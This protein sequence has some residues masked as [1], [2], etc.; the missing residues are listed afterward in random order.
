MGYD[1]LY[2]CCAGATWD[3]ASSMWAVIG[4]DRERR[5]RTKTKNSRQGTKKWKQDRK[6]RLRT[7]TKNGEQRIKKDKD[8]EK[9]REKSLPGFRN[10]F[11]VKKNIYPVTAFEKKRKSEKV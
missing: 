10:S 2:A 5:L 1:I 3:V 8:G 11:P 9:E 4:K 6:P 7:N